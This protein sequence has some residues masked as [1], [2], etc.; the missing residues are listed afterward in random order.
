MNAGWSDKFELF[1][2]SSTT[3]GYS[4]K[5]YGNLNSAYLGF[6]TNKDQIVVNGGSTIVVYAGS[7]STDKAITT[8]SHSGVM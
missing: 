1:T 2:Y 8:N 3:K 7:Y 4:G 6:S 5:S